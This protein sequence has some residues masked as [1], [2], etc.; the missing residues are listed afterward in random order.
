MIGTV[1][2]A[3]MSRSMGLREI[4]T[5]LLAREL[6][7]GRHERVGIVCDAITYME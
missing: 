4:M 7:E 3:E 5:P 6:T 2:S 1:R